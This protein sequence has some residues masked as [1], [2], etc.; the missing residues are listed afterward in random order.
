VSRINLETNSTVRRTA[1]GTNNGVA[2]NVTVFVNGA[3]MPTTMTDTQGLKWQATIDL[4]PGS[5]QLGA[6]ALHPS[7]IFTA[8]ATNTITAATTNDTTSSSFDASGNITLRS[9][10]SANG[11]TNR[12]QNWTWDARN[13]PHMIVERDNATNGYDATLIFDSLDRLL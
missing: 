6:A 8:Y 12:T 5:N 11:Q 2:A 3:P 10:K 7:T 1:Y 13:R 9:W 4:M